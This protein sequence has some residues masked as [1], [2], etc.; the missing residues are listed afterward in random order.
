MF[1]P[2]SGSMPHHGLL[3]CKISNEI[4]RSNLFTYTD[5]LAPISWTPVSRGKKR[6]ELL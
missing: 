6:K 1:K 5:S 3:H 2:L 4:Q